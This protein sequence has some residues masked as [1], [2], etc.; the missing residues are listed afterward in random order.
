MF[1]TENYHSLK[2]KW[3]IVN[4]LQSNS[5]LISNENREALDP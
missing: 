3:I 5:Q 1:V 2:H 4:Q